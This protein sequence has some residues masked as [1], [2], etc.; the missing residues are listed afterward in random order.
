TGSGKWAIYKIAGLVRDGANIHVSRL[1]ALQHG[2]VAGLNAL[3]IEET[4]ARNSTLSFD[5]RNGVVAR[6]GTGKVKFLFMAPEQFG[7]DETRE[8]V[9]AGTPA[10]FVVDEAHCISEWGHDFRPEYLQ[11]GAAVEALGHPTV[12]ALTATA[13]AAVRDEIVER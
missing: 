11:L 10:L 8:R 3:D 7:N 9:L 12:L 6:R 1:M 4:A 2:E 13:T 5:A